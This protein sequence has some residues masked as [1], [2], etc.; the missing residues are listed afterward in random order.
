[1]ISMSSLSAA[2]CSFNPASSSCIFS[3]SA[4]SCSPS[5]FISRSFAA[6]STITPSS[7]SA[8]TPALIRHTFACMHAMRSS[9]LA[10]L[11]VVSASMALHADSTCSPVHTQSSCFSSISRFAVSRRISSSPAC[12]SMMPTS[13]A[14]PLLNAEGTDQS[15]FHSRSDRDLA[16]GVIALITPAA[17]FGGSSWLGRP[18]PSDAVLSS[19]VE[20]AK[21]EGNFPSAASFFALRDALFAAFETIPDSGST[22]GA[23]FWRLAT[24]LDRFALTP[25][26]SFS[27]L[28]TTGAAHVGG[29]ICFFTFDGISTGFPVTR[30]QFG[31]NS[32]CASG[33]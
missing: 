24:K 15:K 18:S 11:A 29:T 8:R 3:R 14:S 20:A 19:D 1:M 32:L 9:A 2:V 13:L 4:L 12:A 5:S 6:R 33:M 10:S 17:A 25:L 21:A 16:P 30:G 31:E 23:D 7:F 27:G 28:G 22:L 26:F